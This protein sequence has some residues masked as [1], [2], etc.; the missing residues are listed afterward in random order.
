MDAQAGD[1]VPRELFQ[2]H[3]DTM[4]RGRREQFRNGDGE[5]RYNSND[6]LRDLEDGEI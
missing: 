5:E 3:R 2:E 6:A 1:E 4:P